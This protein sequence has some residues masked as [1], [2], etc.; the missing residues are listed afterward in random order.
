V[1]YNSK[2]EKKHYVKVQTD[3]VLDIF[4]VLLYLLILSLKMMSFGAGVFIQVI[5]IYIIFQMELV[6]TNVELYNSIYEQKT[7]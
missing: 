7:E 6:A 2:Y 4:W 5:G 3:I 1:L